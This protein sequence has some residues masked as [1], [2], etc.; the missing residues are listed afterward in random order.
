MCLCPGCRTIPGSLCFRGH[1]YSLLSPE[2]NIKRDNFSCES[3]CERKFVDIVPN[4]TPKVSSSPHN[5]CRQ[6]LLLKIPIYFASA[7]F[8]HQKYMR[9]CCCTIT[10]SE[11][12]VLFP[13]CALG[14]ASPSVYA[15][16]LNKI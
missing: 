12:S 8:N 13:Y 15:L 11:M 14:G 10:Q 5:C 9:C 6:I 4:F 16:L 2:P 3:A 7:N 1:Y